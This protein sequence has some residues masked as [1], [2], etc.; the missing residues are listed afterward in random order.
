MIKTCLNTKL[1]LKM[2]LN[3]NQG[4]RSRPFWL[5]P[6]PEISKNGRL[7][8][9]WFQ[10]LT[11]FD[12][13]P[14]GGSSQKKAATAQQYYILPECQ[15][16]NVFWM[17]KSYFIL[18]DQNSAVANLCEADW[19]RNTA[20]DELKKIFILYTVQC[21]VHAFP[22][23]ISFHMLQQMALHLSLTKK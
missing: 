3:F 13:S 15:I 4:C 22:A 2:L 18:Q 19:T 16:I 21:T 1:K 6:E 14:K 7:R 20:A 23:Y 10:L 17:N 9:T 11:N 8:Q 12:S 5:E